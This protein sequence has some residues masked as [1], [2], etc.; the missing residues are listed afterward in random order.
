MIAIAIC[1]TAHCAI[2]DTGTESTLVGL[3]KV[4]SASFELP[5]QCQRNGQYQ[6]FGGDGIS[7]SNDGSLVTKGTYRL[8]KYGETQFLYT[9]LLSDNGKPN[10]Q[11]LSA[12]YV[13]KHQ[14]KKRPIPIRFI[15]GGQRVQVFLGEDETAPHITLVKLK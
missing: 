2:A 14:P 4:E 15:D 5:E 9:T 7:V 10:C 1:C 8:S 12:K 13:R 11:G 6:R 3:W